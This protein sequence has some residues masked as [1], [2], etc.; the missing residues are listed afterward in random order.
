[1]NDEQLRRYSRQIMLPDVD[2]DGQDKLLAAHV[3]IIGLGGLGSP[4][5]MYLAAAGVGHLTL[6]DFDAVDL[7]NLQRQ[8]VHTTARIGM[9]KAASAA[10]SLRE[11]NPDVRVDT[12]EQ[13]LD[14]DALLAQVKMVSLVIDCTDNFQTR[15][16]I[17]AACVA[18][19]VPLV[20]GAAIRLEGQVAV[21]D[22]RL[23]TS[24]CYRCLYE[25]DSDDLTCAANGVLAPLVGVIGSMQ[26]LEAIKLICGFGT[27]LAGRL[28]LLDA[29]HSQW[30][31]LKLPKD[32]CCP[33]CS[34]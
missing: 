29:R 18:A 15:F 16:A 6:V 13:L 4:V 34:K 20:S 31:E 23:E 27:G 22:A 7:T 25:E 24:P 5:A 11:L 14:A 17:N 26:A 32:P 3:L 1:M 9:N 21:F 2:L 10:Q 28:L 12:I 30:R 33:L 19:K 8:I